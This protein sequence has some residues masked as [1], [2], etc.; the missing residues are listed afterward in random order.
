MGAV[1]AEKLPAQLNQVLHFTIIICI[2]SITEPSSCNAMLWFGQFSIDACMRAFLKPSTVCAHA[3][4]RSS[5]FQ[6]CIAL[7]KNDCL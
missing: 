2:V 6:S 4:H 3:T 7:M 5:L 1:Q